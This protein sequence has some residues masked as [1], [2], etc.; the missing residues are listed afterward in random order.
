MNPR[1]ELVGGTG[2]LVVFPASG[3]ALPRRPRRCV[4][5]GRWARGVCR[6]A[7][8]APPCDGWVDAGQLE[9]AYP[10]FQ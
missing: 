9:S 2:Q 1:R 3:A 7:R 4:P 10:A 6:L 8:R 5:L